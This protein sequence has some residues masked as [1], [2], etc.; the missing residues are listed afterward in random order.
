MRF[1][2][3]A[4]ITPVLAGCLPA[5]GPS[6]SRIVATADVAAPA[7]DVVALDATVADTLAANGSESLASSFGEGGGA[8][9]LRIGIG[10]TVVVTI[11]E[12]AAGGLFSGEA[13]SLGAAKSV[14][15]PPQPV[16][17]NGMITVPYVGPVKAAGLTPAQVQTSI[18]AALREKAIEPQ[19]IVTIADSASTFV[20][21]TGD[22]GSP[23]RVPLNLNGDRLLDIVASSGGSSA[24]AY[25]TFVR[26]TRGST[27]RTVSLSRIVEDPGQNVFLQ[28]DDQIFVFKDPQVYTAFGATAQN[29]TYPF[30]TDKLTLAEAVGR[31]GGLLDNR[32]DARGVFVFRYEKP[33]VYASIANGDKAPVP[34]SG[35]VPVV[36]QLDL[37]QPTG[38][39]AAQRFLMRDNDVI[40]VSNAPSTDLQKFFG[41]INGGVGVASSMT[42]LATRVN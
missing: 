15:L 31:S 2:L 4:L 3:V 22:V 41:I 16:A 35:G 36:Y 38:Y 9:D 12:A 11:F 27:S 37:K 39:F 21:V 24:A 42:G 26:L 29:A 28:P 23:G 30:E 20:T 5:A 32:A 14:N 10:D 1:I 19:V 13:G 7:F 18:E 25:D 33:A 17:R 40:F 34:Q 8:P 6:S